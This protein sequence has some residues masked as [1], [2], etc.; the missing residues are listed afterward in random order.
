M[1]SSQVPKPD[2]V[3]LLLLQIRCQIVLLV[4]GNV[5]FGENKQTPCQEGKNLKQSCSPGIIKIEEAREKGKQRRG[6]GGEKT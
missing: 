1:H 5:T 3:L 4:I 2:L 6:E